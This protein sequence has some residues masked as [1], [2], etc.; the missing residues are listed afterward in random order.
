MWD[1]VHASRDQFDSAHPQSPPLPS[2]TY[3]RQLALARCIRAHGF[4]GYPDP[5]AD[6]SFAVGAV[7]AGFVKP[8]LSR[9][10]RTAINTCS[11]GRTR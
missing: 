5:N 6:G 9:Q 4:P 8:N 1:R 3:A 10:A 11:K 2:E 7:P